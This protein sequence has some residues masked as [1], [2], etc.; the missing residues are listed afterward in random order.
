MKVKNESEVTQSY[1]TL[2]DP[3]DCSLLGSSI[4]GIFQARALEWAAIAF[5]ENYTLIKNKYKID[6]IADSLFGP[7]H[8]W[9][10]LGR[11]IPLHQF[12]VPMPPVAARVMAMAA[13]LRLVKGPPA[14][15]CLMSRACAWHGRAIS[16]CCYSSCLQCRMGS[17]VK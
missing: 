12:M 8:P 5:S 14:C 7:Q 6:G 15:S 4:H 13:L 1:P 17:L 3:M 11:D 2:C 16:C 10:P 9:P